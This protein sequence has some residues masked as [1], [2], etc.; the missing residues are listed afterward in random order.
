MD[1]TNVATAI[2]KLAPTLGGVIGGFIPVPGG[3]LVGET[4]GKIV[5]RQ[6]GVEPTPAAVSAAIASTPNDV[7]IAKLKA[8]AE[9]A[10]AMWP[11][12]AQ[13]EVAMAHL[14]EV[15]IEQ[16][17]L[18]ARAELSV[19]S[20]FKSWWRPFNGWVLGFENAC[21]GAMLFVALIQSA[22]GNT[23]LLTTMQAGWPL[24]AVVLGVPAA[25]VGVAVFSRGQAKIAALN[26]PAAP[27]APPAVKPA[28]VKR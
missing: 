11:A 12:Y 1:W 10:K 25:V 21:L 2:G 23:A 17:N 14:A 3:A 6:F 7:A 27:A 5:A 24:I 20:R 28:P 22:M 18:T 15:Q 13:V 9:E 8:A 26:A 4:L 16:T 19:D